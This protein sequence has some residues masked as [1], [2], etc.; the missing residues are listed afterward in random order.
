[1]FGPG[2]VVRVSLLV[3]HSDPLFV[4]VLMS[5]PRGA[6]GWCV[7]VAFPGHIHLFPI[8]YLLCT[9]QDLAVKPKTVL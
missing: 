1:M 7:N 9:T 3:W 8:P 6:V 5:H 2:F 4:F